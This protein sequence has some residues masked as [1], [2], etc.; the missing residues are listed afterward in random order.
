MVAGNSNPFTYVRLK[1]GNNATDT[2]TGL[3]IYPDDFSFADA[4]VGA[5]TFGTA[6]PT[7][8]DIDSWRALETAGCV[9]LPG[10][11]FRGYTGSTPGIS[12]VHYGINTIYWSASTPGASQA[13][14]LDLY[15][16][17]TLK[18]NNSNRFIGATVRLVQDY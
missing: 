15:P 8:I 12:E 6:A 7:Q 16:Y 1:Y 18:L 9:F 11:R 3:V 13:Y 17:G 2:V 10:S 5:M 14:Y 4:G